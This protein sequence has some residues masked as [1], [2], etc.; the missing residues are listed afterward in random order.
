MTNNSSIPKHISGYAVE[1]W[2]KWSIVVCIFFHKKEL[3]GFYIIR[4]DILIT[5]KICLAS[6]SRKKQFL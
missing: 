5:A 1:L 2:R 6:H 4:L 3:G